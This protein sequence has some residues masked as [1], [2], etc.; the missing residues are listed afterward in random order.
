MV[1]VVVTVLWRRGFVRS[2]GVVNSV[3]GE[4][5]TAEAETQAIN[6]GS[7]LF[8]ITSPL[9]MRS[10]LELLFYSLRNSKRKCGDEKVGP[11]SR[12]TGVFVT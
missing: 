8:I 3:I 11:E 9:P 10:F 7:S 12:F 1:A 2:G 4:A 5:S 6:V